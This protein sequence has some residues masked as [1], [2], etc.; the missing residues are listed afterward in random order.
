MA[1]KTWS[2][3]ISIS[4]EQITSLL[5]ASSTVIE[6]C[7]WK[8]MDPEQ[9]ATHVEEMMVGIARRSVRISKIVLAH[10]VQE[11]HLKLSRAEASLFCEKV[12]GA[13][14]LHQNSPERTTSK[15]KMATSSSSLA[16]SSQDIRSVLG[17]QPLEDKTAVDLVSLSSMS[18]CRPV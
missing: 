17:L 13:F 2:A 1:P 6:R 12:C 10:A 18:S 5:A 14:T 16:D 15:D 4:V 7:G 3:K 8:A 11:S 9:F